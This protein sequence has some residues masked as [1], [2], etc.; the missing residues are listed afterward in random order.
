M[1]KRKSAAKIADK[2]INEKLIDYQNWEKKRGLSPIIKSLRDNAENIRTEVLATAQ[3]QL[4]NGNSVDTVL[5]ELSF[6][7]M[8]KLLHAPTVNLCNITDK[9]N[10]DVIALVSYLYNLDMK[11]E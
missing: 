8:N 11:V 3:K 6:K 5:N 10:T 9:L 1:D 4:Q 7:L 2:I